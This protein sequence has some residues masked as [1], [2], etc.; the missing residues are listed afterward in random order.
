MYVY[1]SLKEL[2]FVQE[3]G[4]KKEYQLLQS[5]YQKYVMNDLLHV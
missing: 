5:Q 3:M 1:I 4:Y 2:H